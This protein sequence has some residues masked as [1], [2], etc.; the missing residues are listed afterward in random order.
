MAGVARHGSA[1]WGAAKQ[2]RQGLAWL[3]AAGS[4]R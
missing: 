4:G 1:R 3:G 2:G